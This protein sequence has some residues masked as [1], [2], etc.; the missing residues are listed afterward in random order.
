MVQ[1]QGLYGCAAATATLDAPDAARWMRAAARTVSKATAACTCRRQGPCARA[2]ETASST[3]RGAS[4]GCARVAHSPRP[5]TRRPGRSPRPRSARMHVPL[6]LRQRGRVCGGGQGNLSARRL[7]TLPRI[8]GLPRC[9][10]SGC[11]CCP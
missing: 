7:R 6:A 4:A 5:R 3:P 9:R 1:P 11:P 10:R 8:R 2:P